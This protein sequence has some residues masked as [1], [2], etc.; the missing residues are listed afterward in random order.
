MTNVL[1]AGATGAIGRDVYDL[2]EGGGHSVRCLT[3]QSNT[4]FSDAVVADALR[5]ETLGGIC[6]NIEIVVSAL[7]ASVGLGLAGRASYEAVDTP[8]NLN[9]LREAE[10]GGVRR[11]VYLGVHTAPGYD[12][13]RYCVAHE[14]VCQA[15]AASSLST[16][17]IRPT[18]VFTALHDFLDMARRGRATTIGDGSAR[19]NPI[20][21]ADVAKAVV[22][23]LEDGPQDFSVG[24]PEVMTRRQIAEHAFEALGKEAKISTVPPGMVRA[25]GSMVRLFHPRLGDL[26]EF[27]EAVS[28]HDG[29]APTY[30]T[31]TLSDYFVTLAGERALL[32][33]RT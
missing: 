4:R 20:H 15:L 2:L 6:E 3:R 25:M 5:P 21:P 9:L 10:E 30:G 12:H 8:A 17:V 7:G 18:G 26:I 23:H 1:L 14:R 24:G 32:P 19:T 28:T 11:F 13:T 27:A 29:I 31:H 22:E 16:T 33:S